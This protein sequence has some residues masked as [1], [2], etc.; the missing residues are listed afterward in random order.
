MSI[1]KV[2][3][4]DCFNTVFDVSN[5]PAGMISE[6]ANHVKSEDFSPF[7]FPAPWWDLEIYYD[8]AQ[9]I[10]EISK[11]G[12]RNVAASNGSINLISKLS[13]NAGIQWDRIVDFVGAG[14]YKPN[15]RAYRV[16]LD[17]ELWAKPEDIFFVTANPTFGDVE[18]AH[19]VG[20]IP[21]VLDRRKGV[22]AMCMIRSLF[23][24]NENE[25]LEW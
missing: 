20:M 22:D 25:G 7:E 11:R 12:I 6:Y 2:F 4:W 8:A 17:G 21:V 5:L 15:P 18:G 3:V 13:C 24:A 16:I 10:K 14:V 19:S 23:P 1:P 9:A